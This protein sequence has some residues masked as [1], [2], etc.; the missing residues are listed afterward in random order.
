M[1]S[2]SLMGEDWEM[3]GVNG[4]RILIPI[5]P[6]SAGPFVA[7]SAAVAAH[8]RKRSIAA[9]PRAMPATIQLLKPDCGGRRSGKRV[10]MVC[11][12]T[13]AIGH[14]STSAENRM[15]QTGFRGVRA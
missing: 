8:A 10:G 14:Q 7:M 11:L 6:P 3:T 9:N 1:Q 5:D 2:L 12:A 4:A 13:T 15:F